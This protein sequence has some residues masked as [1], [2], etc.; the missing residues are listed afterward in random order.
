MRVL[1]FIT[2]ILSSCNTK[3][4]YTFY[5][6]KGID[7]HRFENS[8]TVNEFIIEAESLKCEGYEILGT[9][10]QIGD[11]NKDDLIIKSTCRFPKQIKI[12][13]SDGIELPI[14]ECDGFR[15]YGINLCEHEDSNLE[16]LREFYLNPTRRLDYPY[17]PQYAT[18]RLVVEETMSIEALVP[19]IKRIKS[20]RNKLG[21]EGLIN[22][23]FLFSIQTLR[24]DSILI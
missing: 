13:H 23:P 10:T 14:Y 11:S 3:T 2:I 24:K 20:M 22:E 21:E 8:I 12:D 17:N 1:L 4:D 18:V 15:T 19:L 9:S 7:V 16:L 5:A 6:Q